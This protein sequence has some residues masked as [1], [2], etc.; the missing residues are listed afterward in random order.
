MESREGLIG[1]L[2]HGLL[3]Y[4]YSTRSR[5]SFPRMAEQ[6]PAAEVYQPAAT[7]TTGSPPPVG[8]R[9]R[10]RFSSTNTAG[11]V[12]SSNSSASDSMTGR[13]PT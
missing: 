10:R 6:R 1:V 7:L 9:P 5:G 2:A 11:P 8:Q 3:L 12:T 13:S 4:S